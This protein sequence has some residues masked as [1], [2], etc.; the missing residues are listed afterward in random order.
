M[1]VA[2][3]GTRMGHVCKSD[4]GSSSRT[5]K[6]TREESRGGAAPRANCKHS[7]GLR[8]FPAVNTASLVLLSFS[9]SPHRSSSPTT[10]QPLCS[11]YGWERDAGRGLP[12]N[13]CY[14]SVNTHNAPPPPLFTDATRRLSL[15]ARANRAL[16]VQLHGNSGTFTETLAL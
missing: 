4:F 10:R 2:V 1:F 3:S 12:P 11:L 14:C 6:E 16:F 9:H 5:T 8:C 15:P 7:K 13:P